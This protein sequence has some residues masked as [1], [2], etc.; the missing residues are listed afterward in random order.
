MSKFGD[1]GLFVST[2][3]QDFPVNMLVD[4]GA[5]VTVINRKIFEKLPLSSQNLVTPVTLNLVTATGETSAFIGK[6]NVEI[7]IGSHIINHEVLIAD[8]HND[9]ILG[10]DFLT[11][12]NCD[13]LLNES[14]LSINGDRIPC[15]HFTENMQPTICRIAVAHDV[16]VPPEAEVIVPIKDC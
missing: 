5:S 9:G 7:K 3:I 12:N 15:Y 6:F 1:E 16:V 13:V 4:T 10:V 8:I 11:P 2:K 14:C